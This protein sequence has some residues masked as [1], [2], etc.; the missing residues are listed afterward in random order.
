MSSRDGARS[1]APA[2]HGWRDALSRVVL[3]KG[4]RRNVDD[5]VE[6]KRVKANVWNV[7]DDTDAQSCPDGSACKEETMRSEQ[8]R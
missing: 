3:P 4:R 7:L 2:S 5:D 8:I 1:D 6:A